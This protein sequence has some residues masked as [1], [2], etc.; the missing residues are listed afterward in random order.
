MQ[1]LQQCMFLDLNF[2][3]N[4]KVMVPIRGLQN[5]GSNVPVALRDASRRGCSAGVAE[6]GHDRPFAS[7][8]RIDCKLTVGPRRLGV[9]FSPS[10]RNRDGSPALIRRKLTKERALFQGPFTAPLS[11]GTVV[12]KAIGP[13]RCQAIPLPRGTL[14]DSAYLTPAAAKVKGLSG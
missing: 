12:R 11:R 8:G 1:G 10:L 4:C 13:C 5:F 3:S 9:L 14:Y 7:F 6:F 2:C